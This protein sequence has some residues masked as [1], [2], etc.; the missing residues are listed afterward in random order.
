MLRNTATVTGLALVTTIVTTVMTSHG[1]E[2]SLSAVGNEAGGASQIAFTGGL[3]LAFLAACFL[4]GLAAF[5][6]IF[7][8]S[9]T[10]K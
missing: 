10:G 8:W 4:N 9:P 5:V 1:L 6:S 7:Q 3:K 2:P